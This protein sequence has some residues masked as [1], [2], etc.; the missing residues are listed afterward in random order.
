V[1]KLTAKEWG[2]S[3]SHE[4]A[5]PAGTPLFCRNEYVIRTHLGRTGGI[6]ADII[7]IGIN[8]RTT[9]T[10]CP[11]DREGFFPDVKNPL[12]MCMKLSRYWKVAHW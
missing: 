8:A 4:A 5:A 9:P 12:Y 7:R 11:N 2:A 10:R 1:A 6:S 3:R